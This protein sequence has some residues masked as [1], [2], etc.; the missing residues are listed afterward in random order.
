MTRTTFCLLALL[1]A[2]LGDAALAQQAAAPAMTYLEEAKITVNERARANGYMRVR[3]TAENGEVREGTLAIERRMSENE[4][5]K[6]LAAVLEPALG[7]AYKVD[8]DAGEHVK[9]RKADRSQPNFAVE[10]TFN[11]TGFSVVLDEK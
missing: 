9:I 8:R 5:A 3:V 7:P 6:G 4:I 11:V 10:I 2:G 1:G